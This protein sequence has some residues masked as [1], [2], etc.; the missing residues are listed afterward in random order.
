MNAT[1]AAQS[2][3]AWRGI[4][5]ILGLAAVLTI[6]GVAVS[7]AAAP[8][9]SAVKAT[10]PPRTSSEVPNP[11]VKPPPEVLPLKP[12]KRLLT[13]ALPAKA[14][15]RGALAKGFPAAVPLAGK[16]T[17]L[18]SSVSVN[19]KTVQAAVD[20]ETSSTPAEV[21]AYYQKLFARAGLPGTETAS[22]PESR[23]VSF[24]R[25][26]DSVTLTVTATKT[27]SRYSLF[28]V[29]RAA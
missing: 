18:S 10:L 11:L 16:S 23:S 15:A 22:T 8:V 12:V 3:R 24:V 13:G 25:G 4:A 20:A 27:G 21:V 9:P 6:T 5:A 1:T 14:S 19:G 7:F 29:L 2:G 17:V 26:T 28:G